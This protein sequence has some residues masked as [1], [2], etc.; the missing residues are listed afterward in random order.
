MERCQLA[1]TKRTQR[2]LLCIKFQNLFEHLIEVDPIIRACYHKI[3]DF[4]DEINF[5]FGWWSL[6]HRLLE[7]LQIYAIEEGKALTRVPSQGQCHTKLV[8]FDGKNLGHN[9]ILRADCE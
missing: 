5:S 4:S 9:A 2:Q 6:M 8:D 1:A 3:L 7:F